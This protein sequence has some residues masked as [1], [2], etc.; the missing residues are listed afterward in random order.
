MC[1]NDRKF[2]SIKGLAAQIT[3]MLINISRVE[4]IALKPIYCVRRQYQKIVIDPEAP[5]SAINELAQCILKNE[6]AEIKQYTGAKKLTVDLS[7]QKRIFVALQFLQGRR[8]DMSITWTNSESDNS[9]QFDF[10]ARN[11][12]RNC[13]W[14]REF[15]DS[16]CATPKL[17]KFWSAIVSISHARVREDILSLNVSPKLGWINY[18]A[19]DHYINFPKDLTG[20]D[21][22]KLPHGKV[23]TLPC[24][25][26]EDELVD[27]ARG[28][29]V[30]FP[31]LQSVL[32]S[33]SNYL[34]VDVRE[35]DRAFRRK[36]PL[37][38]IP[39]Y[40]LDE[41]GKVTKEK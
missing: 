41:N 25:E 31:A 14:F 27:I 19:N 33:D 40:E 7:T 34:Y 20:F 8:E 29:D 10:F 22:E 18:I 3:E 39:G 1:E 30:I 35:A 16:L 15:L 36:Y 28:E 37:N 24:G 5:E 21:C 23:F 4:P 38:V 12:K 11:P 32:N 2:V 26:H 9:V 17:Y 6:S 13:S